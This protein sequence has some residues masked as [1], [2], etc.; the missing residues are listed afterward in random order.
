MGVIDDGQTDIGHIKRMYQSPVDQSLIVF[1]GSTGINWI[2]EQCGNGLKALN[3]GKRIHEF[4]FH[5]FQRNWATAA[6][7]TS[8]AEFNDD[9]PCEIY[10]EIY[11]TKDLGASW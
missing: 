1:I 4:Q 6:G 7:W 9:E 8:C 2:T 10:K 3:S 11:L 5:P